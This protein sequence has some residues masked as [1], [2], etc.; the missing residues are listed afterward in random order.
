MRKSSGIGTLKPQFHTGDTPRRQKENV[1]IA[2]C[3]MAFR[4]PRKLVAQ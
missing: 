2:H 1:F 3:G 4:V